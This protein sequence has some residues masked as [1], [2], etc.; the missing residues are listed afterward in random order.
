MLDP[1]Y[2][3]TKR[4]IKKAKHKVKQVIQTFQPENLNS[5]NLARYLNKLKD[6]TDLQDKLEDLI[7]NVL[8]IPPDGIDEA[9]T[10]RLNN[11]QNSLQVAVS[12]HREAIEAKEA[13]F[14]NQEDETLRKLG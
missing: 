8:K 2:S 11:V 5:N 12:E 3:V 6:V 14:G 10:E 9:E 4:V 13:E 1:D 7:Y